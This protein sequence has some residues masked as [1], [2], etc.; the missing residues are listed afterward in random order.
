M[1]AWLKLHKKTA[2]GTIGSIITVV[3]TLVVR[4]YGGEKTTVPQPAVQQQQVSA[5][6]PATTATPAWA[7]LKGRINENPPFKCKVGDGCNWYVV[8][9]DGPVDG[10]TITGVVGWDGKFTITIVKTADSTSMVYVDENSDGHPEKV[11]GV[12]VSQG[13]DDPV[14]QEIRTRANSDYDKL[15]V[16]LNK[17][18]EQKLREA[19]F[20][21]PLN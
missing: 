20:K 21:T 14:M 12:N 8:K 5:P 9:G 4:N 3:A 7:T 17:L 19:V 1:F 11:G 16:W 18:A 13:A 6:A 15:L 10:T 2:I